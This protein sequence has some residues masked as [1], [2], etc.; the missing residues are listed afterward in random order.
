MI[1]FFILTVVM[2]TI[3]D[4]VINYL[5]NFFLLINFINYKDSK[6]ISIIC[7]EIF[8]LDDVMLIQL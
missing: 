8:N 5:L 2:Q 3:H 6:I 1:F 7:I 4:H